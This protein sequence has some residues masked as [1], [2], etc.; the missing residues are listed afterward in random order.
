MLFGI[1]V[2][3][4]KIAISTGNTCA[5][6]VFNKVAELKACNFIKK[7][8]PTQVFSCEYG[9]LFKN[10]LFVKHLWWLLLYLLGMIISRNPCKR[11][12]SEYCFFSLIFVF[13]IFSA[14]PVM[15]GLHKMQY[16]SNNHLIER[17]KLVKN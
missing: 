2:F 10:S 3:F 13:A 4:K 12:L 7:E 11:L 6:S 9:K 16:T 17:N 5:E 1:S 14:D 8:T 15:Q